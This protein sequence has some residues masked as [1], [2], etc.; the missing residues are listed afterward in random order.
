MNAIT[1]VKAASATRRGL[2]IGAGLVGGALVVGCSPK[3][4]AG[5]MSMGGGD[6]DLGPFGPFVKIDPDGSVTVMNKHQ[7]MG[8]GNHAGLAALIA[9]ELDADWDKVSVVPSAANAKLYANTLFGVQGTGGSTAMANSWLQYRRAGA[10]ARAMFVQA[11]S[12][13]WKVPVSDI[14]VRNGVLA[15]GPS[16]RFASFGDLIG[17]AAKVTP[18]QS[19]ALKRHADFSLIGTKRVARKDTPAKSTGTARYTQDVHLPDMLTAVVAHPPRFGG[20]PTAFDDSA[21]RQV[22]GVVDVVKIPTGV[23]VIAQS[24]YAARTGRDALKV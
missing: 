7:E 2:I 13:R 8:Q 22:P 11:A 3:S 19:P 15:H 6:L 10:A 17:E 24:T 14:T 20:K 18:P 4:M 1:K 16:G 23:A 9:E 21:T 5:L 12:A